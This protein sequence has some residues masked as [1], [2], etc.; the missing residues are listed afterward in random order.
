MTSQSSLL[1]FLIK[2]TAVSQPNHSN[3]IP[4]SSNITNNA[5]IESNTDTTNLTELTV[6]CDI[7]LYISTRISGDKLKYDLLKKTWQPHTSYYFPVVS[8][9]KL[10]FQLFWITR[11]SWLVY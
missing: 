3:D 10:K 2:K 5:E 7:G 4:C 9:R 1:H 6:M 11:F 8:K